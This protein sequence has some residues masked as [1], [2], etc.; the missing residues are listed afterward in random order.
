MYQPL[1]L[2]KTVNSYE[3]PRRCKNP[4]FCSLWR[5]LKPTNWNPP[6]TM[7]I[8]NINSK[9]NTTHIETMLFNGE[10]I[11]GIDEAVAARGAMI[12]E[13]ERHLG[14][15]HNITLHW[16]ALLICKLINIA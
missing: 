10:P 14:V 5:P 9:I 1:V 7:T 16:R 4:N 15:W 12:L 11:P 6:E 2:H 3:N 8:S 13:D